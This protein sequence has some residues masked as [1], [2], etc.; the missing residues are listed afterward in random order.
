MKW[1]RDGGGRYIEL[2]EVRGQV[3]EDRDE[4]V[5]GSESVGG[6][7]GVTGMMLGVWSENEEEGDGRKINRTIRFEGRIGTVNPTVINQTFWLRFRLSVIHGGR[8]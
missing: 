5:V 4:C 2:G 8:R 6:T 1:V 3:G 7:P